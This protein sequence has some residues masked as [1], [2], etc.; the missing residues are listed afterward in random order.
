M[1]DSVT[2]SASTIWS[3]IADATSADVAIGTAMT[4]APGGLSLVPATTAALAASPSGVIKCIARTPASAGQA[5][6]GQVDGSLSPLEA[7]LVGPGAIQ[8]V[9]VDALGR[10]VRSS[11]YTSATVGICG[12]DGSV[13][14]ALAGWASLGGGGG[15]ASGIFTALVDYAASAGDVLVTASHATDTTRLTKWSQA[16]ADA[17]LMPSGVAIIAIG[18]LG[19]VLYAPA[20]ATVSAAILGLAPGTATW[21]IADFATGRVLRKNAPRVSQVVMGAINSKGNMLIGPWRP[22]TDAVNAAWPPYNARGDIS[23]DSSAAFRL[24]SADAELSTGSTGLNYS[25]RILHIPGGAYLLNKPVHIKVGGQIVEGDSENGTQIRCVNHC[26]PAFYFGPDVGQFPVQ[27]NAFAG[28]NAGIFASAATAQQEHY[29]TLRNYGAGVECHGKGAFSIEA[30]LSVTP[31]TSATPGFII[32]SYGE[33]LSSDP[34][35]EAFGLSYA[36]ASGSVTTNA[37]YFTITTT[38]RTQTVC[39]P[40]NSLPADGTFHVVQATWNG[41][42]MVVSIDGVAQTLSVPSGSASIGGTLVQQWWETSMMGG[43][44]SDWGSGRPYVMANTHIASLRLSS[45]ARA[46]F[47]TAVKY[48]EDTNTMFLVNFDTFDG[49]FVMARSRGDV[50]SNL[51]YDTYLPHQFNNVAV[52]QMPFCGIRNISITNYFGPAID[53]NRATSFK[54]ENIRSESCKCGIVLDQNCF[55]S[56]VSGLELFGSAYSSRCGISMVAAANVMAIHN[57]NVLGNFAVD[58]VI[59]GAGDVGFSGTWYSTLAFT[60]L[61]ISNSFNITWACESEV[62][63]EASTAAGRLPDGQFII[64]KSVDN[65]VFNC[66][67]IGEGEATVPLVTVQGDGVLG[68]ICHEWVA[69]FFGANTT[70]PGYFNVLGTPLGTIACRSP[71]WKNSAT[72]PLLTPG[73]TASARLISHPASMNGVTAITMTDANRTLT[74]FEWLNGTLTFAGTLTAG[75][76]VTVPAAI[77]GAHTVTNNTAQTLT[78][79]AAGGVTTFTATAG[80]TI[81]VQS[82]GTELC[83]ST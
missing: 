61:W 3:A 10:L 19:L 60:H 83:K 43:A 63:D 7:P 27:P 72:V 35:A 14:L 71:K 45:T 17:G 26:G 24:A 37:V 49:S 16:S 32:S 73:S 21:G 78:F 81:T 4:D 39:T 23:T 76:T 52:A 47:N 42:T 44:F 50:A 62:S 8:Y 66:I 82:N 56:H 9:V 75:R 36:G 15:G 34:Y 48:A 6:V 65:A 77:L 20:G 38:V 54:A 59:S 46:P 79:V 12:L 68:A 18:V 28:G 29:L 40:N 13:L 51:L 31:G 5:F 74:R 70:C 67:Q 25:S 55:K 22:T 11:T 69:P 80:Q 57:V 33:R 30:V 1:G 41:T 58:C 2:I 64:L 53:C